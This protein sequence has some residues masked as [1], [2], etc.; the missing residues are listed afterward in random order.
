MCVLCPFYYHIIF[1]LEIQNLL[2]QVFSVSKEPK[3]KLE[4]LQLVYF[5]ESVDPQ[6]ATSHLNDM[7]AILI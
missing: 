6:G 3:A 1:N 5:R 4:I 2:S 7:E